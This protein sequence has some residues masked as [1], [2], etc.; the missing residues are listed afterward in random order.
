MFIHPLE[1]FLYYFILYSPAFLVRQPLSSFLFYMVVN[2]LFGVLDHCGIKF[3]FGIY[4]TLDHD[5]HHSLV[6]VN[7]SF[8]FPVIDIL[9][10]T[11]YGEF[12]GMSFAPWSMS[13]VELEKL[14]KREEGVAKSV[15]AKKT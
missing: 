8:P 12:L 11:Y 4:R 13:E 10:G 14:K 15:R 9:H 3:D 6:S 7:Y 1:A 2:G 5:R